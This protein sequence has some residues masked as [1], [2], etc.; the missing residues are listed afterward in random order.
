MRVEDRQQTRDRRVCSFGKAHELKK[1]ITGRNTVRYTCQ[2]ELRELTTAPTKAILNENKPKSDS[3]AKMDLRTKL[4]T[5]L[6][7]WYS[8]VLLA[9]FQKSQHRST[10][11]PELRD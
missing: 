5:S 10:R 8:L 1:K 7:T 3:C 9:C 11:M 4:S 2:G 6:C